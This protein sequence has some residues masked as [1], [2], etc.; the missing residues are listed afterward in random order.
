MRA[1]PYLV[2]LCL[3]TPV[4]G[5]A[6]D[7]GAQ[8]IAFPD[9]L[10]AAKRGDTSGV[11]RHRELL[12]D[13]PLLPYLDY[14]LLGN[15]LELAE[16]D[17]VSAFLANNVG[18]P[19]NAR[20]QRDWLMALARRGRWQMFL[21]EWAPTS[22]TTLRCHWVN[23]HIRTDQA[24]EDE[25]IAAA[26]E[27]WLVGRSQPDACDPVFAWMERASHLTEGLI[28]QRMELA[29]EARQFSRAVWLARRLDE[30]DRDFVQRWQ[31]MQSNPMRA[32]SA[33]RLPPDTE[34]ERRLITAGLER[35]ARSNPAQARDRLERIGTHYQLDDGQRTQ[36]LRTAA[37]IAAQR[38]QPEAGEWLA[39][40]PGTDPTVVEW[41]VRAALRAGDWSTT[42]TVIQDM[43]APQAAQ[44]G[45]R[46]W[47]ARADAAEGKEEAAR[48]QFDQLATERG[49]HG[50]LA[51]D[52][53]G[54]PYNLSSTALEADEAVLEELSSRPAFQRAR[55]FLALGMQPEARAEWSSAIAT[56]NEVYLLQAAL[57]AERWQWHAQ[58]IAT[59]NRSGRFDHLEARF[60]V[61]FS[62]QVLPHA[63]A[64]GL[65]PALVYS[66]IRSES[67]FVPDARS[68]A[69]ALGLMQLMPG[70][71][72]DVA[73][74]L[75][76][77]A[78][79]TTALMD[80]ETNI[81]LGSA[82]LSTV[83]ARFGQQEVLATAAYNA[84]P[85]RVQRWLPTE[86]SLPA[87]IWVETIPFNETRN[88]VRQVMGGTAVFDWRLGRE[89]RSLTERM[90]DIKV[91][92]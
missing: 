77:R 43:P 11:E 89:A 46:Y 26:T 38:H 88:Y 9:A 58:A 87:D 2:V 12:A 41:R 79:N 32:L 83:M 6:A 15:R 8:R 69:G 75:G 44:S 60:P 63:T 42:R 14:Y 85:A 91:A 18:L 68:V 16:A 10:R 72:R 64:Q 45:W 47:L 19:V 59:V 35:L 39:E 13:Y 37:M 48:V 76:M 67:L 33:T 25:V 22:D 84:G 53:V 80:P 1:L 92:D 49:Y 24:E 23:A 34:R 65:D 50:W 82:Y 27:L 66:L 36:I 3:F 81:R 52:R 5:V 70:T 61:L 74:S 54:K 73:R 17:D 71:G 40:V 78:P 7:L 62:Q 20:L 30:A 21:D 51:A 28:Q 4:S 90:Q 29:L 57:L 31:A 56:L 86:G 55:E